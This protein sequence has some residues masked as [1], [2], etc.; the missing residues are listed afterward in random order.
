MNVNKPISRRKALKVMGL[1]MLAA[2]VPTLPSF[3]NCPKKA[4]SI[5]PTPPEP[6]EA[7]RNA[8]YRN[9]N[10]SLADLIK[11]NSQK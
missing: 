5:I 3:D 1:G 10:V 9:P 2:C 4:I 6:E 7:N 8:R 11:A